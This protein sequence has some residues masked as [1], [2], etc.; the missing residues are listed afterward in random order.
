MNRDNSRYTSNRAAPPGSAGRSR[1]DNGGAGRGRP[2]GSGSGR[3]RLPGRA[4]ERPKQRGWLMRHKAF[5]LIVLCVLLAGVVGVAYFYRAFAD[6]GSVLVNRPT[7]GPGAGQGNGQSSSGQSS[8]GDQQPGYDFPKD[9]VNI[10]ILGTDA[11]ADRVKEGMNARTDCIMLA[12]INTTSKQVSLISIPRDTYVKIYD[13]NNQL[14]DQNRIN[15]A[16]AYGGGLKKDGIAYAMNTVEQ[17]FGGG[18]PI[19]HYV[20]FDM[21]LVKRLINA[22]G[23]VSVDV[24][25][26]VDVDSIH[27][28]PGVQKLNGAEALV[29]A[30]DRHN[31]PGGDFGRVGH[32]QQVMIA[33]LKM[34]QNKGNI[35]KNIP[36]LYSSLS[37][38][39]VTN[40]ELGALQITALA[41]I[42]KDVDV[43]SVKQYTVQGKSL[44]ISGASI[45]VADQQSK[46]SIIKAV[47]GLDYQIREDETYDH[48]LGQITKILNAGKGIISAAQSLLDNNKQYY[49]ADEARPLRSAVAVWQAASKKNDS[50]S[51]ADAQQDVQTEYDILK[52]LID[53]RKAAPT[54]MPEPTDEPEP[55]DTVAPTDEPVPTD[56]PAPTDAPTDKPADSSAPTD[57]SAG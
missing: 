18:I 47:F 7:A 41:W 32:Q 1:Y 56:A 14:T 13:E 51:M 34:L 45:V 57:A 53:A 19:D 55:T 52:Q 44:N 24:D 36:A 9:V 8:S 26:S 21:D 31:T 49:S 42:A 4:D 10:L 29:Y 20:L 40:P 39:V 15:A 22:V 6:P 48:L 23:G 12:S 50:E 16:F 35:V 54:A 43:S 30:R 28:R 3:G 37:D 46:Q 2:E 25:I 17:F 27:L 5:S 33:L 11:D 38:D